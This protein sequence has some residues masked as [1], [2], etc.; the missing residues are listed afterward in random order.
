[1]IGALGTVKTTPSVYIYQFLLQTKALSFG[2]QCTMFRRIV[3]TPSSRLFSR[4]NRLPLYMNQC[5]PFKKKVINYS[6]IDPATHHRRTEPPA[7]FLQ[8]HKPHT[9]VYTGSSKKMDIPYL[10]SIHNVLNVPPQEKIKWR[11]IWAS[12]WPGYWSTPS[13]PGIRVSLI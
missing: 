8:N 9:F 2:V 7:P 13:N 6:P 4:T 11:E 3:A 12:R 10:L 1:M 5:E